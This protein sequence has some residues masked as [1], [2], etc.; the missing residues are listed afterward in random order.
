MLWKRPL[1][2]WVTSS[3]QEQKASPWSMWCRLVLFTRIKTDLDSAEVAFSREDWTQLQEV[4]NACWLLV[5]F[6]PSYSAKLTKTDNQNKKC[7]KTWKWI[8]VKEKEVE[9]GE[10]KQRKSGRPRFSLRPLSTS[11]S[12]SLIAR[13]ADLSSVAPVPTLLLT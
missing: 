12:F 1:R 8:R 11:F 10:R 13:N 4:F 5:G 2:R 7:Q 3:Y 9:E 6:S